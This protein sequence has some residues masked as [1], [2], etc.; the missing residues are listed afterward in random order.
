MFLSTLT[1]KDEE[2]LHSILHALN[3]IPLK[4]DV[5]E[6]RESS[7]ELAS[8]LHNLLKCSLRNG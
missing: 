2:L 6:N 8:K 3:K 4:E 7:Y 1:E 5:G